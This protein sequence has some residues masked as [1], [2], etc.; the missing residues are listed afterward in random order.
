M[1]KLLIILATL[2]LLLVAAGDGHVDDLT[3]TGGI[4]I[5]GAVRQ[6]EYIL[7]A[8]TETGCTLNYDDDWQVLAPDGSVR[9]EGRQVDAVLFLLDNNDC[10]P[11]MTSPP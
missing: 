4:N 7:V 5:T 3:G 6:F 1:K 11:P 8:N 2:M 10:P 9:F